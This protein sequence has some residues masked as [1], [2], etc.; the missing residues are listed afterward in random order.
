M[1]SVSYQLTPGQ[2]ATSDGKGFFEDSVAV[3]TAAPTTG[4]AVELRVDLANTPAR[5]QVVQVVEAFLRRI[6]GSRF[7]PTDFASI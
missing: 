5:E 3:G 2:E 7:G 1:T 6:K 4:G